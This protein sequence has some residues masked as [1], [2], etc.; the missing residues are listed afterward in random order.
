[1]IIIDPKTP[2]EDMTEFAMLMNGYNL[3][4]EQENN[5]PTL[6]PL[7]GKNATTEERDN[8][9]YTVNGK[10]FDYMDHR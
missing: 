8:E 6:P 2:S 5:S 1:M 10:A 9:I 3:D 4:L 7:D